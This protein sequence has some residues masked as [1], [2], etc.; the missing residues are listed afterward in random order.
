M[1]MIYDFTTRPERHGQDAMAVDAVGH[2]WAPGAPKEGFSLLPMWVADMN[3]VSF[4]GIQEAMARRVA[5]P[6]FGYFEPRKEYYQG[7]INWQRDRNGVTD[8]TPEEIGYENGVLG[9]V[10]SAMRVLCS[11]GEAVL[12]HSPTYIGFT[13]ALEEN[14]YK[15]VHSP[16]KLDGTQIWRMDFDD[17]EKKIRE[18]KIHT[19]VFCSPHNPCGRVWQRKELERLSALC[20]KYE[21]RVIS[22]EIWSDILM[23]GQKHMPTHS[24]SDYLR[25]H[26]VSFYAPSK[27]FNLAG[28]V[29]SYHIIRNRYLRDR[30]RKAG[31]MSHYN[32]MNVLSMHALIGAY[33]AEGGN[34]VNQMCQVIDQNI[35]MAEKALTGIHGVRFYRPEGTYMIFPDFR[36]WCEANGKTMDQLEKACWDVGVALQDGRMFHGAWNLRINLAM[37]SRYVEEALHRL[38]QYVFQ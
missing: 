1:P 3:F 30:V 16:L 15:M 2:G 29:G 23:P 11:P 27:T 13:H 8:L 26:T 18:E 31:S 12:V 36:E 20:E 32:G 33:T 6:S 19:M 21:V 34:W 22:D 25:D 37:P 7:I 5:H 28:L 24:V 9:G 4:P 35:T 17:M 10:V 38:K 14:G